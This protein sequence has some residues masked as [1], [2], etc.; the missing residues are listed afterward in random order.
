MTNMQFKKT[1]AA[2]RKMLRDE[3]HMGQKRKLVNFTMNPLLHEY[4]RMMA[5][6]RKESVS[7]V[8]NRMVKQAIVKTIFEAEGEPLRGQDWVEDLG[9]NEL[10]NFYKLAF[11]AGFDDGYDARI[12]EEE[13]A[14]E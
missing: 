14:E 3:K 13:R 1:G 6:E 11:E 5:W 8:L 4:L 12:K 7:E 2:I 10:L 9:D